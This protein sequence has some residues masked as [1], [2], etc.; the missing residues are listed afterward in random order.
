[1]TAW[2]E[3]SR[4]NNRVRKNNCCALDTR[5]LHNYRVFS[6]YGVVVNY[7]AVNTAPCFNSYILTDV[8]RRSNS[9]WK[10]MGSV[11]RCSITYRGE[12]SY[13]DGV[14]FS[15]YSN[16]VPNGSP[17]ADEDVS[18]ESCVRGYPGFGC[19][20]DCFVERHYLAMSRGFL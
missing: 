6:N 7:T 8:N 9:T 1:L 2:N 12:L 10:R 14:V 19:L 17:F 3:S 13:S 16:I 5:S 18:Y 15:S 20:R 11:D 4:W